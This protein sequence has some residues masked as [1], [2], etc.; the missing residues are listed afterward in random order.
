MTNQEIEDYH[1]QLRK[2]VQKTDRN[3]RS[4]QLQE[5]AR[6]VGAY[7]PGVLTDGMLDDVQLIF[8]IRT[9]LQT[10][11]MVNMAKAANRNF[12][13]GLSLAVIAFLS[14]AAAWAAVL[15]R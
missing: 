3:I 10:A 13:V 12:W 9:V 2:I 1:E 15:L 14:A 8:G 4:K 7:S 6:T 11:L 5:L